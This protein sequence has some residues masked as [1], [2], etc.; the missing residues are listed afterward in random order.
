M[1]RGDDSRRL[2]FDEQVR[3]A[4]DRLGAGAAVKHQERA[5]MASLTDCD[6]D[7]ADA[8]DGH[9]MNGVGRH[10]RAQLRPSAR[11][12]QGPTRIQN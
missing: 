3:E 1:G 10:S 2:G 5:A 11:A 12:V 7:W 4:A 8:L 9:G 6:F